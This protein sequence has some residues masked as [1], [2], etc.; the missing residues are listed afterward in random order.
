M[1]IALIGAGT[2]GRIHAEALGRIEG[3]SVVAFGAPTLPPATASLAEQL[4]A[5]HQPSAAAVLERPDV[6]AVVVAVPTDLHHEIVV[7]AARAGKQIICEKPLARTHEQGEA[8]L[9]AV[10]RAGVKLAVA[11]VVRYF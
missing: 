8:M 6:D 5:A 3:V 11:H 2:M 1:R 7:A 4:G 9:A 10:A